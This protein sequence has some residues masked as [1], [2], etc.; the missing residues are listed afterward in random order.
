M[1][2]FESILRGNIV[3]QQ[4]ANKL[5]IADQQDFWSR[6]SYLANL[7]SFLD[8][9]TDRMDRAERVKVCPRDLQEGSDS[10]NGMLLERKLAGFHPP[11]NG[12]SSDPRSFR[13][14]YVDDQPSCR[15]VLQSNCN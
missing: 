2:T 15:K 11:V 1:K 6:P 10:L 8:E 4:E 14:K 9:A 5:M 7:I 12:S 3:D 13:C